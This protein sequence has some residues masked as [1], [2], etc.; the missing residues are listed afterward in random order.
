[1]KQP[2]GPA[3][4]INTGSLVII[5]ETFAIVEVNQSGVGSSDA[6]GYR[7]WITTDELYEGALHRLPKFRQSK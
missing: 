6:C 7:S 2:T 1:M 5:L 4:A 3:P